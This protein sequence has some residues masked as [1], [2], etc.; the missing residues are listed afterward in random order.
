MMFGPTGD[1]KG[2]QK[3]CVL[4][5]DVG[6]TLILLALL[7]LCRGKKKAAFVQSGDSFESVSVGM[8]PKIVSAKRR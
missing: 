5:V 1:H 7:I 2:W 8:F 6:E 4:S 3:F